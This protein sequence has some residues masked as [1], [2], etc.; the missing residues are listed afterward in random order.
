MEK[1]LMHNDDVLFDW[2]MITGDE[3]EHKDVLLQIVKQWITIRANSF[4]KHILET[5]KQEA[6]KSTDKSRGLR[7]KLFTDEL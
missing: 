7:T 5:Y 4:A 2:L 6:K 1:I 3:E